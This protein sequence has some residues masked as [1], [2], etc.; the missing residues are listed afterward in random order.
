MGCGA[1]AIGQWR[2][3]ISRKA[4]LQFS[5]MKVHSDISQTSPLVFFIAQE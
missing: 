3:G 2:A 5:A 1:F 4:G